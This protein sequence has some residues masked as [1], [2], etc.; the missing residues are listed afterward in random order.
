M[1]TY[2]PSNDEYRLLAKTIELF[3]KLNVIIAKMENPYFLTYLLEAI[4]TI[5]SNSIE[6]IHSTVDSEIT[7]IIINDNNNVTPYVRYRETLKQAHRRLQNNDIIRI[8]DIKWI[9]TRIRGQES[10]FRKTPIT[11]EDDK[12]NVVHLG[13]DAH[14]LDNEMDQLIKSINEIDDS[15]LIIK[16]LLIHHKFE[17]IHPFLDGNGRTG[18]I[19]LAILFTKFQIMD[20]PTSALS[21]SIAKN[22]K[23][24]YESL[25][26]ADKGNESFYILNM[27]QIL[28]DSLEITIRF[29]KDVS[30]AKNKILKYDE[31]ENSKQFSAV[32]KWSFS[33]V[34]MSNKYLIRKTKLNNKTVKKYIDKLVDLSVI[35]VI[36]KGKYRIY[37][38]IILDNLLQKYFKG[39]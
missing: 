18:R 9:N 1:K 13:V 4:D 10:S 26:K 20:I 12:R 11:I 28:N 3:G 33:S 31:V 39:V 23:T 21:Y 34:R 35:E 5:S 29:A 19:L 27:L 38:N 14:K 15:N 25:N 36:R 24:Y 8:K 6:N 22:K 37:K 16:A 30:I 17:Y 2:I 32:A 7:N